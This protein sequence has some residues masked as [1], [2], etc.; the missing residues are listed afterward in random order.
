MFMGK[1]N[2][3]A[4]VNH[5]YPGNGHG[6]DS[7]VHIHIEKIIAKR[8]KKVIERSRAIQNVDITQTELYVKHH[9]EEIF[10]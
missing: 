4:T 6:L 2:D 3:F 1:G 10:N 5:V 8:N 7:N 9:Y